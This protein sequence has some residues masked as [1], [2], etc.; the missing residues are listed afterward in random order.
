MAEEKFHCTAPYTCDKASS[1]LIHLIYL[2]NGGLF[3]NVAMS[4]RLQT[5]LGVT[6]TNG[7]WL[8]VKPRLTSKLLTK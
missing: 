4:F 8:E 3:Y 7:H 6:L 5:F 1:A 2:F